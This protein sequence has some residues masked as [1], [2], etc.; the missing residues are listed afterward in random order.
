MLQ[1][2][3]RFVPTTVARKYTVKFIASG[4]GELARSH[5]PSLGSVTELNSGLN[6]SGLRVLRLAAH[7]D[8]QSSVQDSLF[9]RIVRF[10]YVDSERSTEL[11]RIGRKVFGPQFTRS[12][13]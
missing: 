12:C 6:H 4:F 8:G 5:L 10:H 3:F 13:C 1:S 9:L 7:F 11:F 2:M